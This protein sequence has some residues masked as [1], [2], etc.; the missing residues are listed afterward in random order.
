MKR[1][2]GQ[3][4]QFAADYFLMLLRKAFSLSSWTG[5]PKFA[6]CSKIDS[7]SS[8]EA[9]REGEHARCSIPQ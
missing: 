2:A 1:S 8:A 9:A 6:D 3:D 4:F 5:N 7:A